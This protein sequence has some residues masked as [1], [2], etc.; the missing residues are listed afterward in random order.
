MSLSVINKF[1]M[2][3][4]RPLL[5]LSNPFMRTTSTAAP[6]L[7]K[8]ATNSAH[9]GER[10]YFIHLNK[11]SVTPEILDKEHQELL[12]EKTLEWTKMSQD[13]TALELEG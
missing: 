10:G 2:R 11:A 8:L 12:W 6:D 5:A 1:V 7:I 13:D 9:P 4:F 3:P